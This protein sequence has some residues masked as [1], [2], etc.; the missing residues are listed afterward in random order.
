MIYTINTNT[1]FSFTK[2]NLNQTYY[3]EYNW[4]ADMI[5]QWKI[6]CRELKLVVELV[7]LT[8]KEHFSKNM[9]FFKKKQIES[10]SQIFFK[11]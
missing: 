2:L 10:A 6:S 1:I 9:I 4:G 3:H 8:L 7:F 11:K 5:L